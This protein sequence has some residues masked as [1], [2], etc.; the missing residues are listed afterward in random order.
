VVK[1]TAKQ[2]T[3]KNKWYQCH[4]YII[5]TYIYDEYGN[6][7]LDRNIDENKDPNI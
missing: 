6:Q 7:K 2:T 3:F 4:G 5:T 1:E